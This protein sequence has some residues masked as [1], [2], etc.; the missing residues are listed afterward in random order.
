MN[1]KKR[2]EVVLWKQVQ[3][4]NSIMGMGTRVFLVDEEGKAV[5][6]V[7]REEFNRHQYYKTELKNKTVLEVI[8]TLE[9]EDRKPVRILKN[10][11]LR[12]R[13]DGNGNYN[14]LEHKQNSEDVVKL[15]LSGIFSLDEEEKVEIVKEE[16]TEMEMALTVRHLK[17]RLPTIFDAH[18]KYLETSKVSV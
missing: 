5:Y 12:I 4:R 9:Y 8:M 2:Q 14:G 10:E 3:R 16:P 1:K 17:K 13:F 6:N 15:A 11:Y 7:T 18:L